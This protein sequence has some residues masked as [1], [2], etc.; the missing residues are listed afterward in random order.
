MEAARWQSFMEGI[1]ARFAELGLG[2]SARL[3][4]FA[5]LHF[6]L[7]YWMRY[8][9]APARPGW[10]RGMRAMI[11]APVL[12]IVCFLFDIQKIE[13]TN[14]AVYSVSGFLCMMPA[15]I[16]A[17]CMN[18]GPIVKA[19]DSKSTL[20]FVLGLLFPVYVALDEKKVKDEDEEKPTESHAYKDVR[21]SVL[22]F[23]KTE[24]WRRVAM[25]LCQ[26]IGKVQRFHPLLLRSHVYIIRSSSW[27]L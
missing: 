12:P 9:V 6:V 22:R 26:T 24:H 17:F 23:E 20:A 19:Y 8:I 4:I 27:W 5:A 1:A 3:C 21:F 15:R 11:L 2:F 13:E 25:L 16:I 7:Y 14:A 10:S 18:R